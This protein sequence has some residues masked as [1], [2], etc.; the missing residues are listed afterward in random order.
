V[1]RIALVGAGRMGRQHAAAL[2][3]GERVRITA[4]ADPA[5]AP[6]FD[7]PVYDDIDPLL[8]AGGF[9][10]AL[11]AVPT[12]FHVQTVERLAAAGVPMLCEKPCGL[13]ATEARRI[14]A[15]VR[16][17]PFRVGYWRRQVPELRDLRERI[18]S[19]AMGEVQLVVCFHWDERPPPAAFR[20]PAS[21]GGVL[22][23]VAVHEIDMTRWLTGQDIASAIVREAGV[24][25][26]PPVPGDPESA[27]M[28]LETT[29]GAL[30]LVTVGRRFADG[31]HQRVEVIGT[32]G[33]AA[34]PFGVGEEGLA[35]ISRALQ[36]QA[37]AFADL[38]E[39]GSGDGATVD[40]AVAALEVVE[41]VRA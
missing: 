10:A 33:V 41:R 1:V 4:V 29:G 12:R 2:A 23:D 21:S 30:G 5:G 7:L 40:D 14:A 25:S 28:L 19:G 24:T 16:D 18:A 3:G 20:N 35:R 8:A 15:A 36:R 11:V 37:E 13:N 31:D 34:V 17:V 26:E 6:G 38:L 22:V 32:E 27:A 39:T 9:D